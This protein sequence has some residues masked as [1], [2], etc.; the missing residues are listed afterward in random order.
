[1]VGYLRCQILDFLIQAGQQLY[2][3]VYL[4]NIF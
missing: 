4:G 2:D 3:V 1:M